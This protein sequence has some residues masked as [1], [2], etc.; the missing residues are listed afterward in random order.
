MSFFVHLM[1]NVHAQSVPMPKKPPATVVFAY[2]LRADWRPYADEPVFGSEWTYYGTV[3]IDDITGALAWRRGYVG[4]A[5]GHLPVRELNIFQRLQIG[6]DIQEG[7][8]P[9]WEAA[10]IY[11]TPNKPH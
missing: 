6:H 7:S 2:D 11:A 1:G 9:G 3:T 10:P 5:I 4:I 8:V